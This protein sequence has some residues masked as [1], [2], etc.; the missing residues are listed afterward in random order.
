VEQGIL[1]FKH[2]IFN[3]VTANHPPLPQTAYLLQKMRAFALPPDV[4][5]DHLS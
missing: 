1:G 3:K 5:I 4:E 2:R